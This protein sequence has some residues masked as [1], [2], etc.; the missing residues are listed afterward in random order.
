MEEDSFLSLMGFEKIPLKMARSIDCPC[1]G[2]MNL[3]RSLQFRWKNGEYK[4][5]Y[6]CIQCNTKHGAHPDGR[7]LGVPTNDPELK[8][9]RHECH[10]LL[11]KLSGTTKSKYNRLAQMMGVKELHFGSLD[12]AGCHRARN[13]LRRAIHRE[14][15]NRI[16]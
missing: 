6:L 12:L 4:L 16:R 14:N 1:S 15:F 8:A 5:I 11:D 3:M 10:R 13:C 9:L 2:T 7:P